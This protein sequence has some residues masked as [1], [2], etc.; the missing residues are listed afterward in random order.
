MEYGGSHQV[1]VLF[2]TADGTKHFVGVE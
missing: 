2:K 1:M